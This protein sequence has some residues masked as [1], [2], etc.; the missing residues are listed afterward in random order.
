MRSVLSV[1]G[2]VTL[3]G[4]AAP[5]L[6][7]AHAEASVCKKKKKKDGDK[8]DSKK[9]EAT[10]EEKKPID[11]KAEAVKKADAE[12]KIE[13]EKKAEAEKAEAEKKAQAEK[14]ASEAARVEASKQA[15][16]RKQSVVTPGSA[17]RWSNKGAMEPVASEVPLTAPLPVRN[18]P[19]AAGVET[20]GQNL[21]ASEELLSARI[22][23][24][25]YHLETRGQD[26]VYDVVESDA[27]LKPG[28]DR[29]IDL[30]RLRTMLAY[31]RI[32][33]SEFGVRID[34][35]YRPRL[36]GAR[37]TDQRINELYLSYGLTDSRRKS[38]S[39][40]GVAVGR[41][42]V[43]EAGY[44]QADGAAVRLRPIDDLSV[45]AFAGFTGNP[46]GYNW[47]LRT[48]ET[49]SF[50]W[51]TG[52]AFGSYRGDD[53]SV[54][55]SSVATYGLGLDDGSSGLD[56]FYV[57][58]DGAYA[59]TPE[60]NLF[61]AGW[62]DLIAGSLIQNVEAVASYEPT[63]ELSLTLGIG[64]FSTVVYD[65]Q[66][67]SFAFDPNG[68]FDAAPV[69]GAVPNVIV[70]ENGNPI[71]PFD[72]AFFTTTYT[73]V[74]PR[75][76]YRVIPTLELYASANTLI[77]DTGK[78]EQLSLAIS[79][80]A[81]AFSPL[82]ILPTAGVRWSDPEILDVFGEGTY[83]IDDQSNA[84]FMFRTG[85]GR[86]L[87]GFY[88]SADIRLLFGDID[89]ADGGIDLSYTLPRDWFP[90]MMMARA[91]FRYFR[92]DV[93]ITRPRGANDDSDLFLIPLQESYLG[94]AGLEWR[95]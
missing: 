59:V 13:A 1:L 24:S 27:T 61:L 71:A 28:V 23:L 14:V 34:G 80:A 90:G 11:D 57:H 65:L 5:Q 37:F 49:I 81:V 45:G 73:Q 8:K 82:R 6:C 44:A 20:P 95:L 16:L 67:Y 51:L 78:T 48:S 21:I 64:R 39:D 2:L 12:K 43:R 83:V 33:G 3:L 63:Q 42:A 76:G 9:A 58:L 35:E 41:V 19:I 26:F 93:A 66:S 31:D 69:G 94:F 68:N 85:V 60:L 74:R 62:F 25:G 17:S 53:F 86:E 72:A 84:D 87:F 36:N 46:Y 89:A 92:E 38:G 56:R 52:G 18:Q 40:F 75:I 7:V 77:R 70:D 50:D 15:L 79:K 32:G 54:S 91:S 10:G 22:S 88:A 55:L 30:L 29:D 4:F 47:R